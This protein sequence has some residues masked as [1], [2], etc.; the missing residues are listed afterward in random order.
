[1]HA[2]LF[3]IICPESCTVYPNILV[4]RRNFSSS[5]AVSKDFDVTHAWGQNGLNFKVSRAFWTHLV[6][7]G[8]FFLEK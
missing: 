4:N 1:M 6:T 8:V 7:F 3:K 2:V 5:L